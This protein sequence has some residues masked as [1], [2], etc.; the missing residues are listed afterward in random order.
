[1]SSSRL[2]TRRTL[3]VL[4]PEEGSITETSVRYDS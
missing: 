3:L 2:V 1:M 4:Y